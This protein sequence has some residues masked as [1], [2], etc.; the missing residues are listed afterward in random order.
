MPPWW[1]AHCF[2]WVDE[3]SATV[4]VETS[5]A[6]EVS[7]LRLSQPTFS[8]TGHHYALVVVRGLQPGSRY[9]YEVHLDGR[10]VWP[11]P[12]VEQPASVIL[13]RS[14]NQGLRLAL[15]GTP[16]RLRT[17]WRRRLA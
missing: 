4:W 13:T 6:C 14:S 10:L 7:V 8:V 15:G 12:D 11:P 2:G 1:S 16:G 3:T 5:R 9:P 17:L